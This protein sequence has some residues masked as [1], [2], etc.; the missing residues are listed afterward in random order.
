[1][2]AA[3]AGRKKLITE[4]V[5]RSTVTPVHSGVPVL[6]LPVTCESLAIGAVR[7]RNAIVNRN[8]TYR[9]RSR[10]VIRVFDTFKTKHALERLRV[11]S[12]VLLENGVES[13]DGGRERGHTCLVCRQPDG[14]HVLPHIRNRLDHAWFSESAN[15]SM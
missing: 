1:V 8:I 2:R 7:L 6:A 10:K 15:L 13:L 3:V 14:I 4:V 9:D 11:C 5:E 12:V